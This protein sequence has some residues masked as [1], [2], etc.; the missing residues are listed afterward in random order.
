MKRLM[1]AIA[2]G[3]VGISGCAIC[4]SPY[5]DTYSAFGGRWQRDVDN[6]GRVASVFTEAGFPV[7]E[8]VLEQETHDPAIDA[9]ENE[10]SN[11]RSISHESATDSAPTAAGQNATSEIYH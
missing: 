10:T 8:D 1:L 7:G 5:D 4:A 6:H 9:D 2:I 3:S 11:I